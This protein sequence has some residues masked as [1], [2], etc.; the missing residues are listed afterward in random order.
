MVPRSPAAV[1]DALPDELDEL[2][3]RFRPAAQ[4]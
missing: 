3:A 1:V 2:A 4:A